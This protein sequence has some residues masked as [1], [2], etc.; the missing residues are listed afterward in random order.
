MSLRRTLATAAVAAFLAPVAAMAQPGL[1]GAPSSAY[2]PSPAAGETVRVDLSSDTTRT[3]SLSLP[4]GKSAV[5]DLPTD[6]QDVLVTDPKVANVVLATRR[7]IY[8][9]GV[10]SGQTDAAFFDASGRQMLRLNIRVDQDVSALGDTLN[11]ILPGSSIHVEAVNQSIV[12]SGEVENAAT[13]DKAIRL[14]QGFVAKPE[15]VVNMLNVAESEQVM[16]KVRIVEV[17]RTIIKQLGFNLNALIGQLGSPQFLLG[18]AAT[19]GINGSFLGAASGGY[20]V[21]TTQTPELQVPCGGLQ[22]SQPSQ[23]HHP[24]VRKRRPRAHASGAQSHRRVG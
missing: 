11:R 2:G 15:Q 12:L 17:N 1:V 3:Q 21:N 16:L 6:A 18:T 5:I 19:Y 24:G 22:R 9:L 10:E 4:K 13:A 23:R 20:S 7:R 8:V 14:A